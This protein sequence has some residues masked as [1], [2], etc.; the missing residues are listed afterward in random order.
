MEALHDLA[1]VAERR[2]EKAVTGRI[3]ANVEHGRS[4]ATPAAAAARAG[5]GGAEAPRIRI[6]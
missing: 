4:V 1:V 2:T 3:I 5:L 6:R